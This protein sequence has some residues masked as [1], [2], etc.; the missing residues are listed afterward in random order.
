M[1][2][3]TYEVA[4]VGESNYQG[5]IY[6]GMVGKEAL[7]VPE[8]DNPYD[9]R[10]IRVDNHRGQTIG[11]LP[12]EGWLTSALLDEGK[13]VDAEVAFVGK[14]GRSGHL[15]VRLKVTIWPIAGD[16]SSRD[17]DAEAEQFA[18]RVGRWAIGCALLLS[19]LLVFAVIAGS[20]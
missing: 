8:P 6:K 3:R 18:A 17:L 9:P 19:A 2:G 16:R 4:V 12:R 11:Y 20:R 10:A 14:D 15:G 1:S 13:D 5:A 7:L